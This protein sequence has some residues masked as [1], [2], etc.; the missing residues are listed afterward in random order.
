MPMQKAVEGSVLQA[1]ISS[2]RTS[3]LYTLYYLI[4]SHCTIFKNNLIFLLQNV[5]TQSDSDTTYFCA[6]LHLCFCYSGNNK[7]RRNP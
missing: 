6:A 1:L 4:F 7:T 5:Q 2:F 3:A